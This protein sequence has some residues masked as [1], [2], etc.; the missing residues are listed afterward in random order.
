MVSELN[1]LLALAPTV[2]KELSEE[3]PPPL[4]PAAQQLA[5]QCGRLLTELVASKKVR[6]P[7]QPTLTLTLI[8]ALTLTPDTEIPYP[9]LTSYPLPLTPT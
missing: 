5:D 7:T 9:L 1:E 8:I 6:S 3:L 4:V 2:S